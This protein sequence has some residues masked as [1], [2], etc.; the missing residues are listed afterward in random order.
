MLEITD[1]ATEKLKEYLTERKIT[2]P[3]R[4]AVMQGC[5]GASLGL[6]LDE[7]RT[8]D[9]LVELD[10]LQVIMDSKLLRECGRT[11]VDFKTASGSGCG[12]G[13]GGFIVASE[14]PLP[15]NGHGNTCTSRSCRC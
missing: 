5:A 15:D 9:T 2:G 10:G 11:R 3:V 8:D 6:T 14:I 1:L 7:Q 12:C 13:G 4:V